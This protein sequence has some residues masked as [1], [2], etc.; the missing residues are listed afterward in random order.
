MFL[1]ATPV[2]SRKVHENGQSGPTLKLKNDSR[3]HHERTS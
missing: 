2:S 3:S 1:T